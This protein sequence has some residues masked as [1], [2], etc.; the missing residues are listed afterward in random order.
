MS[1]CDITMGVLRTIQDCY[2][3]LNPTSQSSIR[4]ELQEKLMQLLGDMNVQVV[5]QI[6]AEVNQFRDLLE[7]D[8]IRVAKSNKVEQLKL[9]TTQSTLLNTAKTSKKCSC[10]GMAEESPHESPDNKKKGKKKSPVV[11]TDS[12]SPRKKKGNKKITNPK[13]IAKTFKKC[14]RESV[15]S[16][17]SSEAK[18]PSPY[19]ST[20]N[21]EL[22]VIYHAAVVTKD[23]IKTLDRGLVDELR[24]RSRSEQTMSDAHFDQ[25]KQATIAGLVDAAVRGETGDITPARMEPYCA[26]I[27]SAKRGQRFDLLM[28]LCPKK[29]KVNGK[30]K[31]ISVRP[32]D[33]LPP[34]F[35]PKSCPTTRVLFELTD[36]LEKE[37]HMTDDV[38]GN[39]Q[40]EK[41]RCKKCTEDEGGACAEVYNRFALFF[42]VTGG[43]MSFYNLGGT[44]TLIKENLVSK[45]DRHYFRTVLESGQHLSCATYLVKFYGTFENGAACM[46]SYL[47]HVCDMLGIPQAFD[48]MVADNT[49]PMIVDPDQMDD[50]KEIWKAGLSIKD[51][52]DIKS[53]KTEKQQRMDWLMANANCS[54]SIL[55]KSVPEYVLPYVYFFEDELFEKNMV[56]SLDEVTVS[57]VQ[58]MQ[59]SHGGTALAKKMVAIHGR[60]DDDTSTW[61]RENG[62]K[63]WTKTMEGAGGYDEAVQSLKDKGLIYEPGDKKEAKRRAEKRKA[64][65]IAKHGGDEKAAHQHLHG[66]LIERNKNNNPTNN[67][68]AKKT[69][70]MKAIKKK[71]EKK[72][73]FTLVAV[74]CSECGWETKGIAGNKA[75]CLGAECERTGNPKLPIPTHNYQLYPNP[76]KCTHEITGDERQRMVDEARTIDE[77]LRERDNKM[78][79]EW[80]RANN[81]KSTGKKRKT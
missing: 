62:E 27:R 51:K 9:R 3:T 12:F 5:V 74:R 26:K 35:D 76:W 65:A 48:R 30:E 16:P 33:E 22:L 58:S 21:E 52:Q 10:N 69:K 38:R 8:L 19:A 2:D 15:M 59:S 6:M 20:P 44:S 56:D 70:L 61:H 54:D 11:V 18:S 57:M 53:W 43:D 28:L 45:L 41:G 42:Y 55:S 14:G 50:F 75:F 79:R 24:E 25:F 37:E 73:M 77:D 34:D 71:I 72:Q 36:D 32:G 29:V 68:A 78:K 39:C 80:K 47:K 60:D 7:E 31:L 64:N 49:I 13:K 4:D 66:K 81:K 63:S 17:P 46:T 67:A 23:G 1:T 40:C